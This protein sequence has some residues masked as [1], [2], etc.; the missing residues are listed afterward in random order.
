MSIR[1]YALSKQMNIDSKEILDTIKQQGI[2]DK[3]SP[4]A[5]LTNEEIELVKRR[6]ID[7]GCID[8]KYETWQ[9]KYEK[10][11][12]G[13]FVPFWSWFGGG[14]TGYKKTGQQTQTD[15]QQERKV[16]DDKA[17][18]E[19]VQPIKQ[20][21]PIKDDEPEKHLVSIRYTVTDITGSPRLP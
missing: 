7:S 11:R 19:N 21:I 9:P 5:T 14:S 8:P 15:E 3:G 10:R 17:E 12:I 1:I 20:I 6:L 13:V 18:T 2:E 4:V 16:E